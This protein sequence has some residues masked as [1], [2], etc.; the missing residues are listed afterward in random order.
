M[1]TATH[2]V[3]AALC[4]SHAWIARHTHR[5]GAIGDRLLGEVGGRQQ[6]WGLYE[7]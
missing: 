6:V 2:D 7:T 5:D 4:T 1:R 3:S